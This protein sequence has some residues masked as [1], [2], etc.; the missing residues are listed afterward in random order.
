MYSQDKEKKGEFQDQISHH[1]IRQI[2]ASELHINTELIKFVGF[3][4]EREFG[5]DETELSLGQAIKSL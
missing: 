4:K 2:L 5:R 3:A 1:F